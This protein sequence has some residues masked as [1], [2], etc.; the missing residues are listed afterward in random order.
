M[1]VDLASHPFSESIRFLVVLGRRSPFG[2]HQVAAKRCA[3]AGSVVLLDVMS[4]GARGEC[5]SV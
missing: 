4:L 5:C 1:A 2:G 3:R